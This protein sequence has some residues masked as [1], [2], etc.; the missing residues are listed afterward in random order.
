MID[1]R[2]AAPEGMPKTLPAE[3]EISVLLAEDDDEMRS[4]LTSALR[5][6]GYRVV[7]CSSGI[8]LVDRL[9]ALEREVSGEAFDLVISDIWM[10]G[11]T[12]LEIIEGIH[13]HDA[14]P[15]VIL[16]TAF[17]DATTHARA[18]AL[19]AAAMFDKPFD[20]DDLLAKAR[21]LAP[22]D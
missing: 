5:R 17:G 4:L 14:L 8:A 12:A 3:S 15:P 22:P 21:E 7:E 2:N 6:N 16:I 19:G 9:R 1:P 10:P 13:E 18:E 11:A 20:I